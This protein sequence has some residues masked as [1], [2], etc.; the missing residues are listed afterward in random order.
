MRYVI[1]NPLASNGMGNEIK[2]RFISEYKDKFDDLELINGLTLKPEDLIK[3]LDIK[4]E[5]ILIG[6][7]G[8]IN[9][10]LNK[11][12]RNDIKNKIYLYGGGSGNDFSKDINKEPYTLTDITKYLACCPYVEVKGGKKYFLNNV[13]FGIDGKVCYVAEE[14]KK[15]RKKFNYTRIAAK[16]LLTLRKKVAV[17]IVDG[18]KYVYKNVIL[19]ATM[20]GKYYGGGMKN[21]PDQDRLSNELTLIV[22]HARSNI[23]AMI[24]FPKMIKGEHYK[25]TKIVAVHKGK[26]I[27]VKFNKP[28]YIQVDG[29]VLGKYYHYKAIKE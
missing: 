17:V 23:H 26:V 20:N 12:L 2:D 15:K 21:A 8:T 14:M 4:D 5:I 13:G 7:D 1:Y 25:Y 29:E 18:K 24:R 16:L 28:E 9:V 27:D 6:G 22:L 3:K 19:A 11:Y 10:F